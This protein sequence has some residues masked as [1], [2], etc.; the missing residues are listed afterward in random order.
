MPK[1]NQI[2]QQKKK[3]GEVKTSHPVHVKEMSAPLASKPRSGRQRQC[4]TLI[5]SRS[6]RTTK[7]QWE[8]T[9][10]GYCALRDKYG[11]CFI[12]SGIEV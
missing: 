3:C 4:A 10:A 11:Q 2:E 9:R 12:S 7:T 8:Q 5:D 6:S 1:F